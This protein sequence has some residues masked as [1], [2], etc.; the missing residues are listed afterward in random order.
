LETVAKNK[1]YEGMFLVDSA[2]AG[3]DWDGVMAAIRTILEKAEAE[4][5]SINKWDDRRLAYNIK[6]KTRGVYI[7]SYF[8]ADGGRIRNIEKAVQLSERIMRV[9]ILS[10]ERLRPEDIEKDTPAM[11]LEKEKHKVTPETIQKDEAEPEIAP[12]EA[13][14]AEV[15]EQ[16]EE[17]GEAAV[18]EQP[19]EIRQAPEEDAQG[20]EESEVDVAAGDFLEEQPKPDQIESPEP[21]D[22]QEQRQP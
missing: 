3:A 10:A 7:L 20:P 2:Q 6:G 11:K 8:R 14:G 9:L 22:E 1:L 18:V 15:A 5:V 16:P 12:E 4:I 21:V 19:E 17:G 13:G